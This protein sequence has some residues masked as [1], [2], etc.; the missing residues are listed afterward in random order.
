MTIDRDHAGRKNNA[1]QEAQ[2]GR[3]RYS[4]NRNAASALRLIVEWDRVEFEPM[5]DQ[6]VA[7]AP[8]HLGL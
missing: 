8:R 1:E 7:K 6:P 2:S 5:I 3:Q 4:L